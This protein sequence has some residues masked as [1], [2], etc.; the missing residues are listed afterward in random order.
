M[1]KMI[2]EDNAWHLVER[3]S[4]EDVRTVSDD[5]P[6]AEHFTDEDCLQVLSL[7]VECFDANSGI[8]WETIGAAVAMIVK[9]KQGEMK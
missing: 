4:I 6:G 3:W 5:Y 9:Q 2:F 7:L 1:A 8:N